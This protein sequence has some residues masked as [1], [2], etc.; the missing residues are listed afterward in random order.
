MYGV[1]IESL[2]STPNH[3]CTKRSWKSVHHKVNYKIVIYLQSTR[4]QLKQVGDVDAGEA[5]ER[6]LRVER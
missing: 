1:A 3:A 5:R 4:L 2:T 6:M